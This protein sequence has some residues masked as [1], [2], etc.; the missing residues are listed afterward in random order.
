[1]NKEN[2]PDRYKNYPNKESNELIFLQ[3]EN[4]ALKAEIAAF[5]ISKNVAELD[6]ARDGAIRDFIERKIQNKN[7][8]LAELTAQLDALIR[9]SSEVR[10]LINADWSELAEL[11]GGGFI[12]DSSERNA[13]WLEEYIPEE[14]QALV[15]AEIRRSIDQKNTYHI[16]HKVNRVDGSVG[17]ALS[18]AVPLFDEQGEI[19]SW[20]GA[21]SDITDRK[22]A[23][24]MQRILNEELAHRM[25]NTFTVVQAIVSQTLRQSSHLDEARV[26]ISA[27]LTALARAQD[28]LTGKNFAATDIKTIVNEALK[29]YQDFKERILVDGPDLDLVSQ[30][31][32]GLSL[33]IHELAT[34]ATKYGALSNATGKISVLWNFEKGD[35]NFDWIEADGPSVV[36]PKRRGFGSILLEQIVSAYFEGEGHI[37]F[38]ADGL[39]FRLTSKAITT[40]SKFTPLRLDPE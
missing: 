35:F 20:M 36:S 33:T 26:A 38:K 27:R 12:A 28:I 17:W 15:R 40:P 9:S 4:S 18:R 6:S 2:Y 30:Q 21:A 22:N 32:L 7:R 14:H 34:N 24:K 16:E 19:I 39:K 5:R 8:D 1:M 29:P 37:N 31:S 13:N 23:E 25:K 3:A 11:S 10:Y